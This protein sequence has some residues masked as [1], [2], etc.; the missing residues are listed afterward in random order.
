MLSST[1]ENAVVMSIRLIT[2]C[3]Y[4]PL[5]FSLSVCLALFSLCLCLSLCPCPC[6]YLSVFLSLSLHRFPG[7][8]IYHSAVCVLVQFLMLRLMGRTV[9]A[10]LSS[11]IFQM[12]RFYHFLF[13]SLP[14][15]MLWAWLGGRHFFSDVT[16]CAYSCVFIPAHSF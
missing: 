11:F 6:L 3:I 7:S 15:S 4:H 8:Q 13:P 1:L 10:V 9:T 16:H 5:L 2:N 12:V 14:L